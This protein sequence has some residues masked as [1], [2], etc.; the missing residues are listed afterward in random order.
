[1]DYLSLVNV[2]LEL[3]KTTKRLE[4]TEII[5]N[6]LKKCSEDEIEKIVYLL[7]GR[8]FPSVD[9]R[10]LGMSSK[11]A[12]KAIHVSTGSSLSEIEKL[13]RKMGDVGSVC[14]K[15]IETK[16]QSTLVS[17]K[18]KLDQVFS[19]LQKLASLEGKGTVNKKIQLVSELL[20][21]ANSL[22]GK[23]IVRTIISDLRVGVAAGIL[24][25]SIAKAFDVSVNEV[26][27]AANLT[28]DYGLVAFKAKQ[29]KLKDVK[30]KPGVPLR[31]ML[32]ISVSD[33]EDGFKE[34]GEEVLLDYKLDGFRASIHKNDDD[35][36]I[37]TRSLENITKQFPDVVEYVKKYVKAKDVII[38]SE[39]MG[40]D[41]KTKTYMPF[42]NISQRIKRKYDIEKL[43]KELPVEINVFDV[44]YF[45]GKSVME[46]KLV[47]RLKIVDKI[48]EEHKFKIRIV[49]RKI[50]KS[51]KVAQEFFETAL[52][53]GYE[54]IMLKNPEA[55]YVPG[56]YVNGWYKLKS[57]LEPLD[58]V[59]VGATWGEGKRAKWLS[60]Y[61]IACKSGKDFVEVGKVSTGVKEKNDGVTYEELT[62]LLKLLI[63]EQ[64][65]QEVRVKPEIIVEVHYEEVQKSQKYSSGYALRFPRFISLRIEKPLDE[66]NTLQDIVRI[67]KLEKK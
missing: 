50:T 65:G 39:I 20:T 52:K 25:D 11:L 24:R 9:E 43:I 23:F 10:K 54:G 57:V 4:K 22:E 61:T 36:K 13:F 48:I 60:S 33:I 12:L 18:L 31:L 51:S 6:L 19:N 27:E 45:N 66:I 8:V 38:D 16:K 35:V 44:L 5:S 62:K 46:E 53:L 37:F 32:A 40:Y 29:G 30:F 55:L 15:L 63:I 34:I 56:R 1:M 21:S 3:E 42:Q 7:Q 17:K 26:E 41:P 47:D 59:I 49:E 28:G 64:K 67:Y 2:Y 58:L 14:E